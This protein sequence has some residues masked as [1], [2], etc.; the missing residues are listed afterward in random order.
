MDGRSFAA[1]EE[2]LTRR[3]SPADEFLA[4]LVELVYALVGITLAQTGS[5]RRLP[6]YRIERPTERR[7]PKSKPTTGRVLAAALGQR[8]GGER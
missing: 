7:A 5:R 4:E 1:L 3:W 2:A 8:G 6:S